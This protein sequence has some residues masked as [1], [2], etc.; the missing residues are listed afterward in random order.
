MNDINYATQWRCVRATFSFCL[1]LSSR[2]TH[3]GRHCGAQELQF[4][5]L[6]IDSLARMG[7]WVHSKMQVYLSSLEIPG[8]FAMAGFKDKPY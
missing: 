2:A 1:I 3:S 5:G 7:R 8:A 4:M 6:N